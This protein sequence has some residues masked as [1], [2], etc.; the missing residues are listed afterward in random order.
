MYLYQTFLLCRCCS[1]DE[2]LDGVEF[3]VEGDSAYCAD[4]YNMSK[5]PVCHR[6]GKGIVAGSTKKTTII[7]C[8]SNNYHQECY[9]CLVSSMFTLVP[10]NYY[11]HSSEMWKKFSWSACLHG[12]IG[13]GC[14]LWRLSQINHLYIFYNKLF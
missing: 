2:S 10:F 12:F 1:C 9:L 3:L 4:C 7:T 13:Q 11:L 8:E 6:C 14:Y 5:G